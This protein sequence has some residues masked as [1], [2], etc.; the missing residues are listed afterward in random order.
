MTSSDFTPKDVARFWSK[1][2]TL[3]INDC[4]EWQGP[5]DSRGYGRMCITAGRFKALYA[6]R[7]SYALATG[8]TDPQLSICHTCDNPRCVNPNHLF[9]GTQLDN[10]WDCVSK[11]RR[12][13]KLTAKDI[14][15]IRKMISDGYPLKDIAAAFGVEPRA[16]SSIRD[17]RTWSHLT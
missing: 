3:G 8:H 10:V 5:L 1:V 17:G 6:H 11:G 12:A 7:V 16:I 14:P 15:P 9:A 2:P 13:T 4:W